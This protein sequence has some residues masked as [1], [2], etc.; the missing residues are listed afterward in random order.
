MNLIV[1]LCMFERLILIY[2]I[3]TSYPID[4]LAD[5]QPHIERMSLENGPSESPQQA[6]FAFWAAV[7]G[8]QDID[9]AVDTT[10][11]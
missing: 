10:H 9:I 11:V 4:G 6:K 8:A 7:G 5:R 1:L 2:I 3:M